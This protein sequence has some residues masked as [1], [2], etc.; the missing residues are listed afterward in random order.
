[1]SWNGSI[2]FGSQATV[3]RAIGEIG[4][5]VQSKKAPFANIATLLFERANGKALTLYYPCLSIPTK[6]KKIRAHLYQSLSVKK[7]ELEGPSEYYNHLAAICDYLNLPLNMDIHMQRWGKC[8]I[9]GRITL[10]SRMSEKIGKALRS[11]RYFESEVNEELIFGEAIAFYSLQDHD[12]NLVV[13]NELVNIFD[14]LGRWCGEWSEEC[15]VM[16]TSSIT[17]LVGIWEHMSR[18]HVLRRHGGLDMLNVEEYEI[19]E[20]TEG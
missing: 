9:P 1:M 17:K 16:K 10:R 13:Y 6:E 19:E 15:M 14:V 20:P 11:S 2:R 3:E 7:Q 8:M 4:H 12:C 18:V 5:K